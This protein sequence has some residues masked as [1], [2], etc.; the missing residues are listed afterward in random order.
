MG[1]TERGYWRRCRCTRSQRSTTKGLR[2]RL[3]IETAMF[4]AADHKRIAQTLDLAARLRAGDPL[5]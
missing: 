2:E 4:P 5:S 3:A 1:R